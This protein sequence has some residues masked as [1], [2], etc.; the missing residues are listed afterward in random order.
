MLKLKC[1]KHSVYVEME[2]IKSADILAKL[3]RSRALAFVQ[4]GKSF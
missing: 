1:I 4:F 3:Y 2:T